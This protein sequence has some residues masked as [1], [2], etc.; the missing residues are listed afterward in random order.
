MRSS[1]WYLWLVLS[2]NNQTSDVLIHSSLKWKNKIYETYYRYTGRPTFIVS[3][4]DTYCYE[5]CLCCSQVIDC[6][7]GHVVTVVTVRVWP[8]VRVTGVVGDGT[9]D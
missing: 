7:V 4:P 6:D 9:L 2:N 5:E 3:D 1:V 8:G